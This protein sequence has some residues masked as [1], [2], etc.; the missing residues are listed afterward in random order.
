MG[1][2]FATGIPDSPEALIVVPASTSI[3]LSW[4]PPSE[5]HGPITHYQ[6]VYYGTDAIAKSATVINGTTWRITG[7][8]P[9]KRYAMKVRAFAAAGA[10]PYSTAVRTATRRLR[11]L[12]T[13]H[14]PFDYSLPTALE[15]IRTFVNPLW[16]IAGSW[17]HEGPKN[18]KNLMIS[19]GHQLVL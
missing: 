14:L 11:K 18:Q 17:C 1:L 16:H 2:L 5:Y 3:L 4:S 8:K 15:T 12:L 10:G 13:T 7:L 9:V 19:M 6:V